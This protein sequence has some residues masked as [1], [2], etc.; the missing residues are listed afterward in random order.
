MPRTRTVSSSIAHMLAQFCVAFFALAPAMALQSPAPASWFDDA[1]VGAATVRRIA[2]D[3]WKMW[4]AGRPRSFPKD[5]VP[6]GTGYVGLAESADGI[7]WHRVPGTGELGS[8][9]GPSGDANTFDSSHVAVGDVLLPG[10]EPFYRMLYFAGDERAPKFG[11]TTLPRGT[12]MSIG[13]ATSA[14]GVEWTR[15]PGRL[16]SGAL[17]EPSE[18]QVFIGWPQLVRLPGSAEYRL[19][20]HALAA[21]KFRIQVASS[22]DLRHWTPHGCCLDVSSDA[23]AFD[24]AGVSARSVVT[25]P[26]TGKLLMFYEGQDQQRRHAI[27][28]AYGSPDGLQWT[29]RDDSGPVFEPS[30]DEGAWDG[31]AVARPCVVPM[32]DGS[33]RLYYLGR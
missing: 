20:Y 1:T 5:I 21:D 9:L 29:R 24:A 31:A 6:I 25:D 28:I 7:E 16:P 11:E 19:Y 17:L 12:V 10:D 3:R 2:R 8:V 33:A 13:M 4:Y 15:E 23:S 32:E 27:G 18:G 14:T 26:T 22:S 30:A